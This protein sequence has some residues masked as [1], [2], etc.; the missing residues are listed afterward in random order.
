MW[1]LEIQSMTWSLSLVAE[2][3]RKP[4]R[5]SVITDRMVS[6]LEKDVHITLRIE[7][8]HIQIKVS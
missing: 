3:V 6:A 4:T 5:A 7:R 8:R 1:V 2:I